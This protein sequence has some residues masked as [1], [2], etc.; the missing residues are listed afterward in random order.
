MNFD[1]LLE[2]VNVLLV[3]YFIMNFGAFVTEEFV[4]AIFIGTH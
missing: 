2:W 3:V 4:L 1:Q